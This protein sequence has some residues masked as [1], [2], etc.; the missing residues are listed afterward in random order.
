MKLLFECEVE[1]Y[2]HSSCSW[3]HSSDQEKTGGPIL[4][5]KI[6]RPSLCLKLCH[7]VGSEF[8]GCCCCPCSYSP[9]PGYSWLMYKGRSHLP[10]SLARRPQPSSRGNV[11]KH[12]QSG[13]SCSTGDLTAPMNTS[14]CGLSISGRSAERG[15]Y[16]ASCG[17]ST[18][19]EWL[20]NYCRA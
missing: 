4:H 10:M 6:A 13:N 18:R 11:L 16:P 7:R 2:I 9:A 17:V 1:S 3:R 14:F 12:T 5:S 15:G 19:E 8:L 20:Y